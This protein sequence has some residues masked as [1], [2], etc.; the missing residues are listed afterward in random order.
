MIRLWLIFVLFF[1]AFYIGMPA[2]RQM[3]G[4]EKWN[5]TKTIL[6]SMMCSILA[7]GCMILLVVLF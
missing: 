5:L 3:N 4:K 1:A 2:L 6:Y 7:V